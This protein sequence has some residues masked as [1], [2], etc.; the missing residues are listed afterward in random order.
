MSVQNVV[1]VHFVDVKIFYRN[2]L[3]SWWHYRKGSGDHQFVWT[4]VVD[5]IL[6]AKNTKVHC[7]ACLC[8]VSQS[9]LA[10]S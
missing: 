1:P 4:K 2:S 8:I 7:F 9:N 6:M 5:A 10:I 3:T